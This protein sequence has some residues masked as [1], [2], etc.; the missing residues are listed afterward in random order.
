MVTPAPG[1]FDCKGTEDH[2]GLLGNSE[3]FGVSGAVGIA[4]QGGK[5]NGNILNF[6]FIGDSQS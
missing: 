3:Q 1:G 5:V 4:E 2:T 6:C